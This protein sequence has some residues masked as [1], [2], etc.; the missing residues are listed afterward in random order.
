LNVTEGFSVYN[1]ISCLCRYYDATVGDVNYENGEVT[2]LFDSY[3]HSEV[4]KVELLRDLEQR[5][6]IKRK[7]AE[8]LMAGS[9]IKYVHTTRPGFCCFLF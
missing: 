9:K 5:E 7:A 3:Q 8:G 1:L 2:V 4:T 6:T